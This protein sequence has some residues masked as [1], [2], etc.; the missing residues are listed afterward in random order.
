M[1]ITKLVQVIFSAWFA[2]FKCVGY[3]PRCITLIALNQCLDLWVS[4]STNLPDQGAL[5][6]IKLCKPLLTLSISHSTFSIYCTNLL[7]LHFYLSW[8]NN[9][10]YYTKNIA[11]FLPSSILRWLHKNSP[12]LVSFFF[13]CMLIRQLSQYSLT[14][15]FQTKLKTIQ[16][17]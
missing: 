6:C 4:I 9:K 2:Y 5:S 11:S 17:S 13:K 14:K 7:F 15:L 1:N 3:L 10:A 12:I 16:C 8:N